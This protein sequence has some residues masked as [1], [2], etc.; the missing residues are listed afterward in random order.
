MSNLATPVT[1]A[2]AMM[3]I[4]NANP[5]TRWAGTDSWSFTSATTAARAESPQIRA[6]T[7]PRRRVGSFGHHRA[8]MPAAAAA[9]RTAK[10]YRGANSP[11][12][13]RLTER[14]TAGAPRGWL[15]VTST[16]TT[17]A[18]TATA[19]ATASRAAGVRTRG[20]RFRRRARTDSGRLA[21]TTQAR[22]SPSSSMK[23]ECV[24]TPPANSTATA[25]MLARPPETAR[26]TAAIATAIPST[27]RLSA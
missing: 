14:G 7:I 9:P 8:T 17:T 24:S 1:A 2:A 27:M 4:P 26:A 15:G 25:P 18:T 19:M 21:A 10:R 12:L 6:S 22:I 20:V 11:S 3:G 5:T 13:A 23:T 16:A